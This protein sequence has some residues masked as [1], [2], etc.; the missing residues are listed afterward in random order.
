[1]R[2]VEVNLPENPGIGLQAI[3]MKR[4]GHVVVLAGA[5]GSGK[6]RLL[7]A[8][9]K[10][11]KE[12]FPKQVL[13]NQR[14]QREYYRK[15][16]EEKPEEFQSQLSKHPELPAWLNAIVVD[17]PSIPVFAHFVP[18]ILDL[19]RPGEISGDQVRDAATN[20]A[21]SVGINE[22]PQNVLPRI[23]SVQDEWLYATHPKS[24]MDGIERNA[25]IARYEA[26]QQAIRTFLSTELLI[27][28]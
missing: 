9:E 6:T 1:M 28:Q 15:L 14:R 11:A 10:H 18:K 3:E 27:R 16:K 19:R 5:N 25:T 20:V 22:M 23:Q 12:I 2:I 26:L 8:I 17:S 24:E 13:P 21:N 4:L 7:R